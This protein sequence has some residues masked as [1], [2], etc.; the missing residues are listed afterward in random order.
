MMHS[1]GKWCLMRLDQRVHVYV[2]MYSMILDNSD[3]RRP[4]DIKAQQPPESL[5]RQSHSPA[6]SSH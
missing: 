5:R 4:G 6:R 3:Q 1:V 2:T